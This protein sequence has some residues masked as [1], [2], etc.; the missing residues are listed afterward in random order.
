ML[1]KLQSIPKWQGMAAVGVCAS[2]VWV[3]LPLA[4]D[5]DALECIA[6]D[7]NIFS[8]IYQVH[9]ATIRERGKSEV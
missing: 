5:E 1:V 3:Y 4:V 8:N 6:D 2:L 9:D 7:K